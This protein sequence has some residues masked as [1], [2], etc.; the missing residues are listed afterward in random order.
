MDGLWG[1][2]ANEINQLQEDKY[3]LHLRKILGVVKFKAQ[4][5]AQHFLEEDGKALILW[6]E[7]EEG[8]GHANLT[9]EM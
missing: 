4:K 9:E 1:H 6:G 7:R 5:M 2:Y 3:K 8:G